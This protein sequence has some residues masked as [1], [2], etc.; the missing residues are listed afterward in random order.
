MYVYNVWVFMQLRMYVCVCVCGS[1]CMH[2]IHTFMYTII[3][4]PLYLILPI[5]QFDYSIL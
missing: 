5:M 1:V 2:I 4:F 3:T